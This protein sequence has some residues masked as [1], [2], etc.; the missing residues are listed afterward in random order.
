[1]LVPSSQIVSFT[2]AL[3]WEHFLSSR[4]PQKMH[5]YFRVEDAQLLALAST[6][7]SMGRKDDDYSHYT[8][9]DEDGMNGR[10]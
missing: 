5:G 2:T 10:I 9:E 4:P 8:A 1:M 6:H 3:F 7:V